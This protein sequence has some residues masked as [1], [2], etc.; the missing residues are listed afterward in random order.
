MS[1][2]ETQT[3]GKGPTYIAYQVR[4][5]EKPY[6]T[7]IGAAWAHRDGNGFNIQLD[8]LSL[9]GAVILRVVAEDK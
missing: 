8:S 9:D 2:T 1:T 6:W 3:T 4:D 7:R 5:G